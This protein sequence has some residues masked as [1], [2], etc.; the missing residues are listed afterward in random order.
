MGYNR[1]NYLQRV[2][3][4]QNLYLEYKGKGV[5]GEFIFQKIVYPKYRISRKTI[6]NYLAVNAKKEIKELKAQMEQKK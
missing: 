6:Y 3:D 1:L 4:I 2:I 5:A